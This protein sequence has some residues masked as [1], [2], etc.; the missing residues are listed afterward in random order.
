[1]SWVQNYT[2]S[3][4]R[5]SRAARG[6]RSFAILLTASICALLQGQKVSGLH[7]VISGCGPCP[8]ELQ[9][10]CGDVDLVPLMGYTCSQVSDVLYGNGMSCLTDLVADVGVT[11]CGARCTLAE[12]CPTTCAAERCSTYD[13]LV[14]G[15]VGAV[16]HIQV[17]SLV[18][19]DGPLRVAVGS[20]S[21]MQIE[22]PEL[23]FSPPWNTSVPVHLAFPRDYT[24]TGDMAGQMNLTCISGCEGRGVNAGAAL[25]LS[26]AGSGVS[27]KDAV[28]AADLCGQVY[29][30]PASCGD[31]CIPAA[32]SIPISLVDKEQEWAGCVDPLAINYAPAAVREAGGCQYSCTA[33]TAHFD[34]LP[35]ADCVVAVG[36]TATTS[37]VP[38][39]VVVNASSAVVQ[40]RPVEGLDVQMVWNQRLQLLQPVRL[41]FANVSTL[42]KLVLRFLVLDSHGVRTRDAVLIVEQTAFVGLAALARDSNGADPQAADAGRGG[43][44]SAVRGSVH[45]AQSLFRQNTADLGGGAI[46][47]EGATL[48]ISETVFEGNR[49]NAY[50]GGAI[51]LTEGA[52]GRM[53]GCWFESNECPYGGASVYRTQAGVAGCGQSIFT[54]SPAFISTVS[55]SVFVNSIPCATANWASGAS[56]AELTCHKDCMYGRVNETLDRCAC[57]EG[58]GGRRCSQPILLEEN[59]S[60]VCQHGGACRLVPKNA[61]WGNVTNMTSSEVCLCGPGY[62]GDF[63]ENDI[64]ESIGQKIQ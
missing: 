46:F 35:S 2:T 18:W 63:C 27:L 32:C 11:F 22:P 6:C 8:A 5:T 64:N 49:A 59:C 3:A 33:L 15:S 1:M 4:P 21:L 61:T 23:V 34:L 37:V 62:E 13:T 56:G 28:T 16:A 54:I 58:Y 29:A 17:R 48:H 52:E 47:S 36:R 45:I 41:T 53:Q 26:I 24:P 51:L 60:R 30:R 14:E 40:G 9:Q 57:D 50:W 31:D 10:V 42:S 39:E 55:D 25:P 12:L 19:G 43:A 44:I 38:K 20:S 7:A